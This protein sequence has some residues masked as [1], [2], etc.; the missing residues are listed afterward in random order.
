M[1]LCLIF[2]EKFKLLNESRIANFGYFDDFRFKLAALGLRTV[3][4]TQM[5][6]LLDLREYE[7]A[8]VS[9]LETVLLQ[10]DHKSL[11]FGFLKNLKRGELRL[12]VLGEGSDLVPV[13][14]V[15]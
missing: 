15:K 9:K 8:Q 1:L 3:C 11:C 14:M 7:G 10:G 2:E 4:T 5:F 6:V 12:Q 13:P